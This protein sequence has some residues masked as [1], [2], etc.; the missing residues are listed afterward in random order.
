MQAKCP[1]LLN[2][3]RGPLRPPSPFATVIAPP[4]LSVISNR[5]RA[6]HSHENVFEQPSPTTR[7]E[8]RLGQPVFAGWSN[9]NSSL[10]ESEVN[11]A[12]PFPAANFRPVV[13]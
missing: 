5:V 8:L 3:N 7:S 13:K 1:I 10:F 9:S 11:G 12:N 6:A 2:S 4:H